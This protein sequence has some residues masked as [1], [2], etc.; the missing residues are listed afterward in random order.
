ME[1]L[2]S[3]ELSQIFGGSENSCSWKNYGKSIAQGAIGS[4]II[5][6]GM[7]SVTPGIGTGLGAASGF[8][9][10]AVGGA[11]SHIASCWW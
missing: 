4:A 3:Q 11:A 5:G 7:G 8:V 6:A 9:L 10:G 1:A 2:S